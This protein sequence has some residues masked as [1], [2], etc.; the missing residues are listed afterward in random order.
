MPKV[1]VVIPV[2][3]SEGTLRRCVESI[4]FGEEKD[5]ELILIED[6]SPDGSWAL[7]QQLAQEYTQIVCLRNDQNRGVSY[8]RNRGMDVATGQ[9]LLFVDSDDW[10]SGSYVHKMIDALEENPGKLVVCGFTFIDHIQQNRVKYGIYDASVLKRSDF[11]RLPEACML[12]QLWNKAFVLSQIREAGI[13]F[14]ESICM[15]EDY[16]FVMDVIEVLD[17]QECVIIDQPL[18]YYVR[19][20]SGSLMNSWAEHETYEDAL[21][22]QLRIDRLCGIQSPCLDAFNSGY[23]YRILRESNLTK[24]RKME[25]VEGILGKENANAF[26]R[27]QNVLK[28]KEQVVTTGRTLRKYRERLVG[29]VRSVNNKRIIRKTRRLLK[30]KDITLISQNCIGGVFSHDMGLEFR[31]PTVN[32]FIPAADYIKFV[33]NL[34]HYLSVDLELTWG[35]EYPVGYLD[36]IQIMFVHYETCQQAWDAWE[37]RKRRA[38]LNKVLVLSTDRDGFDEVVFEQWKTISYPKLLFTAREEYASHPDSLYFPRHKK[39]GCV[40]D[41]IP[42]REFYQNQKLIKKV[43]SLGVGTES[44]L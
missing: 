19:Y 40:P 18:Y 44:A 17:Y 2:Y 32:A 38:D 23:A 24:G 25:I 42:R 10:V 5:L 35:E 1:S 33:S 43:N 29:R 26:Y 6:C 21:K 3:R 16:Q 41:L 28:L 36:D 15:G 20:T 34:E 7:C 27:K 22:R 8:T 39:N 11:I 13:R 9:Y 14:N 31:S 4:I 30:Q 37:R 12:Q